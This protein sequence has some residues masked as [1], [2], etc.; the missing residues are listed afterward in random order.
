MSHRCIPPFR[1]S[2]GH[3]DAREH[4]V[5]TGC[6]FYTVGVGYVQ[7]IYTDEGIAREQI[8]GFSNGR[9]KKSATYDAAVAVWNDMCA[10]YHNHRS[11]PP[12]SPSPSPSPPSSPPSSPWSTRSPLRPHMQST[13]SR[14]P[15]QIPSRSPVPP[16]VRA[17]QS[18]RVG[19]V[20]V[21]SRRNGGAWRE[22][23][24]LW[25]IEG[26]LRVFEDRYDLVDYIFAK[27]LSPA[28]I[29]ETRNLHKL[30]VFVEKRVYVRH[31]GDPVDSELD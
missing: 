15:A 24:T 14:A 8:T 18:T 29:M 21:Q 9:W 10:R 19:I 28:Y 30:E 11:E 31:E 2:A 3:E 27:R 4:S 22:G 13:P 6:W 23:E 17:G 7:G 1:P 20:H 5:T 16:V 26:T 25:G 12:P